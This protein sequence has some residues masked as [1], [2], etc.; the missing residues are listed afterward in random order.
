MPAPLTR[1]EMTPQMKEAVRLVLGGMSWRKAA[2]KAGVS[3][4]GLTLA[5]KREKEQK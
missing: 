2:A 5:I 1:G 3:V 4:R